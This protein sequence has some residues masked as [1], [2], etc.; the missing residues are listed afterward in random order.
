MLSSL[1]ASRAAHPSR[2]RLVDEVLVVLAQQRDA[3]ERLLFRLLEARDVLARG[4]DRFLHHAVRDVERAAEDVREL[5][6]VRAIIDQGGDGEGSALRRL[7]ATA[8]PPL[9]SILED[10]RRQLGRL[11]AEIGAVL[12][13]LDELAEQGWERADSPSDDQDELDRAL[14][15]AGYEAILAAS[16]RLRLP[17]LVALLS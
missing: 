12:E 9:D 14:A 6:L 17:S 3:L 11:A 2:W 7:A 4:D 10:L 16:E 13:T 15:T 5:E 8:H 1:N